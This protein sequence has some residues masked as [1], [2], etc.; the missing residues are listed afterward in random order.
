MDEVGEDI[1]VSP[2][3]VTRK[4]DGSVK[5]ALDA[6]ELNRQIVRKTMQRP[7]LAEFLDQ[8]SLKI[9]EGRGKPLLYLQL[10]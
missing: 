7:I 1:F 9:C 10:T 6:A 3:V 4:S 5:I 2:V 8:I